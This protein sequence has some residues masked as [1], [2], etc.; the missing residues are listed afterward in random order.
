MSQ[1]ESEFKHVELAKNVD[2]GELMTILQKLQSAV[3]MI[4]HEMANHHEDYVRVFPAVTQNAAEATSGSADSDSDETC[5]PERRPANGMP[6][7]CLGKMML[8]KQQLEEQL[9]KSRVEILEAETDG[10]ELLKYFG[11]QARGSKGSSPAS[12]SSKDEPAPG[13][14]KNFFKNFSEFLHKDFKTSWQDGTRRDPQGPLRDRSWHQDAMVAKL[15]ALREDVQ[16]SA[17]REKD[18]VNE[19][20]ELQRKVEGRYED[21]SARYRHLDKAS[22]ILVQLCSGNI[23]KEDIQRFPTRTRG[24]IFEPFSLVHPHA[25][26]SL[27]RCS[28]CRSSLK[29]ADGQEVSKRCILP[30]WPLDQSMRTSHEW[31]FQVVLLVHVCDVH[32]EFLDVCTFDRFWL[33][34]G[35][36]NVGRLSAKTRG[37]HTLC[38]LLHVLYQV[39]KPGKEFQLV[40]LLQ[41]SRRRHTSSLRS[42]MALKQVPGT[43]MRHR[44]GLRGTWPLAL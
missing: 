20:G 10:I 19:L 41:S 13:E 16:M 15:E 35:W 40:P 21:L 22:E 1:V 8:L 32:L 37:L 17:A 23:I 29:F 3:N 9:E 7:S 18:F 6:K 11:H 28:S 27:H 14:V 38:S 43:S 25:A 24:F 2:V 39:S 26:K 31:F 34:T 36:Q 33:W 30:P 4:N 42:I 12:P 5:S 44:F